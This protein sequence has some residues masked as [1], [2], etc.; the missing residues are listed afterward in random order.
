MQCQPLNFK[1]WVDLLTEKKTAG[2]SIH[3]EI[4]W[5]H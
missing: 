1:C 3:G 4:I 2:E 5:N